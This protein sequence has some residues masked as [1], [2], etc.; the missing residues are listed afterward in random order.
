VC[1]DGPDYYENV[2]EFRHSLGYV[3]Q[4]DIIHRDLPLQ[5]TLRYAAQLRL[6]ADSSSIEKEMAVQGAWN[7]LGLAERSDLPVKALSS[8]QRKR[9]SIGVELL[10]RPRIFFL[11][12]P[13]SGLDPAMPAEPMRLLRQLS[14]PRAGTRSKAQ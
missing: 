7:V 5:A 8:G 10:S 12:E 2:D 6:P 14:N 1:Y 11:D 9:A 4:D 3:P 13:T